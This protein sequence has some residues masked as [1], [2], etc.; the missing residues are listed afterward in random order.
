MPLSPEALCLRPVCACVRA[1]VLACQPAEALPDWL[2][3]DFLVKSCQQLSSRWRNDDVSVWRRSSVVGR[4]CEAF[5]TVAGARL[6]AGQ[7][8]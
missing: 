7:K 1:C 5:V 4:T 3:V 6:S 2:A 8:L